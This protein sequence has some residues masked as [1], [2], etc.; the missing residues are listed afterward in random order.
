MPLRGSDDGAPIGGAAAGA[1]PLYTLQARGHGTAKVKARLRDAAGGEVAAYDH[2][3]SCAA[4]SAFRLHT[5]GRCVTSARVGSA[6]SS[7][8][9]GEQCEHICGLAAP[10]RA[11]PGPR[12]PR[13]SRCAPA[14]APAARTAR[15]GRSRGCQLR[16]AR[17][18]D[19]REPTVAAALA[20]SPHAFPARALPALTLLPPG[21]KVMLRGLPYVGIVIAGDTAAHT[22]QVLQH[23]PGRRTERLLASAEPSPSAPGSSLRVSVAAGVDVAF[24][25]MLASIVVAAGE[26]AAGAA[27]RRAAAA[28]AA[29][30]AGLPAPAAGRGGRGAAKPASGAPAAAAPGG[31][32]SP[33]KHRQRPTQQWQAAA[34]EAAK[35]QQLRAHQEKQLQEQQH[36]AL[37]APLAAG[38]GLW[39]PAAAPAPAPAAV[40]VGAAIAALARL[41]LAPGS[42]PAAAAPAPPPAPAPASPLQ[43]HMQQ[44]QLARDAELQQQ[45]GLQQQLLLLLA[46]QEQQMQQQRELALRLQLQQQAAAAAAL[47][48]PLAPAGIWGLQ[49]PAQLW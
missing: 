21:F 26:C 48:A 46:Q 47:Q 8:L 4:G 6:K 9:R 25:V 30:A 36:A 42:P 23:M 49:A 31:A 13:S 32:A 1:Q 3:P 2:A 37:L 11:P 7:V 28:A 44:L 19:P 43:L 24:A 33:G 5:G 15:I 39:A 16:A 18:R 17:T 20:P 41:G 27:E 14:D 34:I 10:R 38:A 40:D 45:L 12:D 29:E 35:A 22:F